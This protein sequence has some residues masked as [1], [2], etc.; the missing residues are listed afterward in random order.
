MTQFSPMLPAT[1]RRPNTLISYAGAI[2]LACGIAGGCAHFQPEPLAPRK[3]ADAFESRG[4]DDPGLQAFL[5]QNGVPGTEVPRR[6]DLNSLTWAAFYYQPDLAVARAQWSSASAGEITAGQRPN[7]SVSL[8]PAYDRGIPDNPSPWSVLVPLDVP[9][10][11]AGKRD[12]R[13]AQARALS[14][15]AHWTLVEAIWKARGRVR[16]ALLALQGTGR[17]QGLLDGQEQAQARLVGLMEGQLK[18]G[19]VSAYEVAQARIVLETDQLALQDAQ[20]QS[21]E[22]GTQL[23]EALGVPRKAL[24]GVQFRFEPLEVSPTELTQPEA[25][26]AALLDRADVREALAQYAAKQA[27]LQLEIANQYP[28]VH[29]GPGY[30]WNPGSAGDSQWQLGLTLTLPVLNR[31]EG[32]IAEALAGRKEAA[33]RFLAVQAQAM[34]DVDGA[35]A[36][37]EEARS[38]SATSSA[39]AE[40]LRRNLDSVRAMQKAGEADPLAVAGEE[41]QYYGSAVAL[42]GTL[43]RARQALGAL[44]DATESPL[45]LQDSAVKSAEQVPTPT[46]STK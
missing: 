12:Y 1:T 10:E 5:R 26:R 29:L 35:L 14:D 11:T 9:I 16:D 22:A 38:Q 44:E 21:T 42:V 45:V 25:R 15:A 3:T 8:T 20:R 17:T 24:E 28:D 31:N 41:A 37:Y 30:G 33:A 18:A 2:L 36:S 23:A 43:V 27:A 32:P 6:W 4:L 19:N 40:D 34:G 13:M 39:L 46:A 7:P